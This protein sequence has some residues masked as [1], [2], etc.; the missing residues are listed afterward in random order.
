MSNDGFYSD[1]LDVRVSL[2]QA[3]GDLH[4]VDEKI[5]FCENLKCLLCEMELSA[6]YNKALGGALK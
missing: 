6:R 4:S 1:L 5:I 3:Y 2:I